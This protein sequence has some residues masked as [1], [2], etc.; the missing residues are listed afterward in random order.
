MTEEQ[1]KQRRDRQNIIFKEIFWL[2]RGA[3]CECDRSIRNGMWL[4]RSKSN[5]EIIKKKYVY[6]NILFKT[7]RLIAVPKRVYLDVNEQGT[8]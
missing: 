4:S 6:K 8:R 7:R 3:F 1:G 2:V 5:K